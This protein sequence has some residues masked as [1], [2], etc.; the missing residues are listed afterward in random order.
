MSEADSLLCEDYQT[1]CMRIALWKT[2]GKMY[3]TRLFQYLWFLHM[4]AYDRNHSPRLNGLST[5]CS[6]Q[7]HDVV[8]ES[9]KACIPCAVCR[10]RHFEE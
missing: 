10:S 3:C 8:T 5:K 1:P 2:P 7:R 9:H 6:L 4:K